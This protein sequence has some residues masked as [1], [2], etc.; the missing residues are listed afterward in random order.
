M[1]NQ[2]TNLI[3]DYQA[4]VRTAVELMQR[5]GIPMPLT[6]TDWIDTNIPEIG[7]LDGGIRYFKHGYGC[8]VNL[9]TGK[10]DFD[11]GRQG[12][13]GGFDVWRLTRFAGS[14][15]TEYGFD[16]EHSLEEC[17]KAAVTTGS[18]IYSGYILYYVAGMPRTLA[19]EVDTRLPNDALPSRDQDPVLVLSAHYFLAADLMRQHYIKL[20]NKWKKYSYLSQN[21]EATLGIYLSSWLGFLGVTCE[22]FKKLRM[23]L[24]LQENRP[25]SFSELISK[26]DEIGSIMKQ[27][28]DPLREY[29]NNVFHLRDDIEAIRRFFAY[30]AERLPWANE[31]HTAFAD[32]FSEYRILCEVH[33]IIHHRRSEMQIGQ[34]RLKR[35]KMNVRR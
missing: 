19:V 9:A 26:C 18:L 4:S 32:F 15:L 34:K 6:C 27:H 31:L 1:N 3:S 12:E 24:L 10:I 28:S 33:Y 11:F 16:T 20:D 25:E 14:R 13:I 22:G 23:R 30:D 35:R 21:D 7:E 17:F 8:A 2:L 5:S 29:R